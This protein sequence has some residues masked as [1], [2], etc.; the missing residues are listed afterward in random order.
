MQFHRPSRRRSRSTSLLSCGAWTLLLKRQYL[1]RLSDVGIT[2]PSK[3]LAEVLDRAVMAAESDAEVPD[4]WLR[5]TQRIADC[6]SKTYIAALGT[7]LLAKATDPQIDALTIKSKAGPNAYSMRSVVKVL[8]EKGRIYGYHL[9]RT[10]PEPLNNQPWFGAD[11][12]DR[13]ENLRSDVTP[14]H[15]DMIRYLNEINTATSE[16]AF[17]AL[18]AFLRLRLEFAEA[19]R[20]AAASVVV[21]SSENLAA[22][23][24]VLSIFLNDDPEGGRRGQ[25][26][27]AALLDIA[28]EEVYLAPINDPTGLDVSVSDEGRLLLG[29]EVK[30]KAVTEASA[31]HLAEEARRAGADKA[32]LVALATNQRPLDRS[33]IRREA[34][35]QHRVLIGIWE[36]LPEL[37]ASI[38]LQAPLSAAEFANEVPSVYLSRM[39]EHDVSP[40]GQQYWADL[41]R[42][43]AS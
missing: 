19:E 36:G 27:V 22:L 6:P 17:D 26:L 37:V 1:Q 31:L 5:R 2:L 16:E 7:A 15:R 23:I 20:R 4:I 42:R 43:L 21:K 25:A 32:I 34:L 9:G 24:E 33:S 30:Q 10:G 18:A 14:Y 40:E 41:S 12:V 28:H 13:I 38:A 8:V 3:K 11:R 39:Q 29:F 35:V